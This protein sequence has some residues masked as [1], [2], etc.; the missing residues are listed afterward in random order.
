[1]R[2]SG[3]RG[4]CV[5]KDI[6]MKVAMRMINGLPEKDKKNKRKVVKLIQKV[7]DLSE[8]VT[9]I[10]LISN[11]A[12]FEFLS[13]EGAYHF[14]MTQNHERMHSLI[15]WKTYAWHSDFD[16]F[17]S[18][19]FQD[20]HDETINTWKRCGHAIVSNE[21]YASMIESRENEEE[22]K[23]WYVTEEMLARLAVVMHAPRR[24]R[25][26]T[27]NLQLPGYGKD[28]LIIVDWI[29]EY[30]GGVEQMVGWFDHWHQA[31]EQEDPRDPA[32]ETIF[33]V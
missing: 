19:T 11:M 32:T 10:I 20:E 3:A 30:F 6:F 33:S 28:I 27:A 9:H 22:A 14:R 5:H 16:V 31:N 8:G 18:A 23:S 29:E 4:W 24:H 1:M 21:P 15:I 13:L 2:A 26:R 7:E 25:L 12:H 17:M